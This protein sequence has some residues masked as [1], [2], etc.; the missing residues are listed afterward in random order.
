VG[1]ASARARLWIEVA[2]VGALLVGAALLLH[3][4]RTR[5]PLVYDMVGYAAQGHGLLTGHGNT[6][7][8][9]GEHVPGIYPA[10]VP[11]LAA[12]AM[13]VLGPDLRAG[14]A[15]VLLCALGTVLCVHLCVRRAGGSAW[16]G[17]A[18]ALCVLCS[19]EYRTTSGFLMSQVPSALAV[20]LAL[21]LW[22]SPRAGAALVA[23]G[24]VAM[25]AV[26]L[27]YANAS[28]PLA[29]GVAEL[30][31]GGLRPA[32]RGRALLLVAGGLAAGAG[33][34]LAHNAWCY[35]APFATGYA[36]WGWDVEDQFSWRNVL[37]A[38]EAPGSGAASSRHVLTS[39]FLGLT[40]L[41]A[42]PVVL[43][44]L[45]GVV[46]LWRAGAR[47]RL[48]AGGCVLAI[49][50]TYLF[51]AGY[52]FR[53]E[54]YL[55]PTVPL[56][57]MLAGYGAARLAGPRRAWLAPLAALVLLGVSVARAPGPSVAEAQGI[58]RFDS[59][60]A[61]SRAAEPDA[62]LITTAD[63]GLVEVLY[64]DGTE[65]AVLYLGPYGSPRLAQHTLEQ[66][67][68]AEVTAGDVVA[69]ADAQMRARRAVYLDQ[70]PPPRGS[71]H[72]LL[73]SHVAIRTALRAAYALAPTGAPNVFRLER[74]ASPAPAPVS[75][76]PSAPAPADPTGR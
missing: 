31:L 69:W 32:P 52:A 20:A 70:N 56:T 50:A 47:A 26:L 24:L 8:L 53:S 7:A 48:L 57:A 54:R 4:P 15:A 72:G 73:P 51:L 60:Q 14:L 59:L 34:V 28:F 10:G 11:L 18:A 17:L 76:P 13:A 3:V 36:L 33:L 30:C 16:A 75:P 44:A 63:P 21:L 27:R 35:G 45:A 74:L 1:A 12:A 66:L 5:V 55:V 71:P 46:L 49:G 38:P 65:R 2:A 19:P 40:Q 58:V 37:D 25:L 42:V 41:Q 43:A 39:A 23:A 67:G 29:L 68:V 62:A 61:A 64:R 6:V 9:G 22:L